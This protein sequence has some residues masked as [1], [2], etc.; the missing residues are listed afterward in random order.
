LGEYRTILKGS[1]QFLEIAMIL[2]EE[3]EKREFEIL[4]PFAAKAAETRGRQ[5]EEEKCGVRTDYQRD[6]DR[7]VHSKAFRRLMHKTQVFLAPEGDHFRTRLDRKS[8]V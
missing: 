4:S 6:R 7:I 3:L 5:Y 1:P 2:R 8:V